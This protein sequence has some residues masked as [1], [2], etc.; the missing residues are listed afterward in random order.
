MRRLTVFVTA[1]AMV[2]S[3][4]IA[5]APG[6]AAARHS[7]PSDEKFCAS[8]QHLIVF[9]RTAPNP[10]ALKKKTG[11]KVLKDFDVTA[12]RRVRTAVD[13][14]VAAFVT[15]RDHGRKAL[16]KKQDQAASDALLHIA[17]YGS[18]KCKQKAVRAFAAALVQGR[19]NRAE[20]TTTTRPA[21]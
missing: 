3:L 21:S 16:S 7:H 12:P 2:A 19:A 17:V 9:L 6:A 10:S 8:F 13:T 18:A 15:M 14:T 5:S 11:V 4:G 20:S 1:L